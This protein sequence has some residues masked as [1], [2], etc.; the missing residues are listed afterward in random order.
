MCDWKLSSIDKGKFDIVVS[1]HAHFDR[2]LGKYIGE[3]A[4][5][6]SRNCMCSS[7]VLLNS[8]MNL[9]YECLSLTSNLKLC[10]C[11]CVHMGMFP[12]HLFFYLNLL[13]VWHW[14]VALNVFTRL[15]YSAR[16]AGRGRRWLDHRSILTHTHTP[17]PAWWWWNSMVP[18]KWDTKQHEKHHQHGPVCSVNW[19]CQNEVEMQLGRS[20]VRFLLI[21]V[22]NYKS[23]VAGLN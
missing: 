7:C 11:M 18:G 23:C 12:S 1:W 17:P 21:S 2:S 15:C 22:V 5:T 4:S 3:N 10:V 9:L 6:R 14:L 19:C 16:R 13:H 20:F 8:Q